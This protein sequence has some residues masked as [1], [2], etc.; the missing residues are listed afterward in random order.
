M[1]DVAVYPAYRRANMCG[2]CWK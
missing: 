1:A 2:L